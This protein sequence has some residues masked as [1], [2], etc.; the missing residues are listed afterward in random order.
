[1]VES[2]KQSKPISNKMAEVWNKLAKHMRSANDV[3]TFK[4]MLKT[5]YFMEEYNE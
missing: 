4:K 1:M 3:I 5:T 2:R